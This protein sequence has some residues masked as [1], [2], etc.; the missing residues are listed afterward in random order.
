MRR[1]AKNVNKESIF[2][3]TVKKV[4]L[5]MPVASIDQTQETVILKG[6]PSALISTIFNIRLEGKTCPLK[7]HEHP[8]SLCQAAL[9][10]TCQ[11]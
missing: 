9:R 7:V 1:T 6:G 8:G 5:E 2:T 4:V 11:N 10:V 3:R